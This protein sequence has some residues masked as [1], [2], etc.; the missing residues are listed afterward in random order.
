MTKIYYDVKKI[1]SWIKESLFNLKVLFLPKC[2]GA[3]VFCIGYNKTGTTSLGKAL[4][5]LGFKNSSFNRRV[6]RKL[7]LKG[8]IDAVLN[9]TARFESFDDLP[10]L[11]EDMIPLLDHTFKGSRFIY[12]ERDEEGWK[13]SFSQWTYSVTGKFLDCEKGWEDYL[14]HRAFVMSYFADRQ[15]DLL[16]LRISDPEGFSKLGKFLDIK[17]EQKAFPVYNLSRPAAD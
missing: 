15:E 10:W 3:K 5:S 4:E 13:K 2:Y 8:K 9:Y 16:V 17:T 7:Y 14:N 1:L 6:W 11:K 12:L